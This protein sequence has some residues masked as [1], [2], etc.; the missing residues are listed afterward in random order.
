MKAPGRLEM[1]LR[2]GSA[3]TVTHNFP[4]DFDFLTPWLTKIVGL[5]I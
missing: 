1:F 5:L 3:V 4:C 2:Q